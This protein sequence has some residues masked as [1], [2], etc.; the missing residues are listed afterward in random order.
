MSDTTQERGQRQRRLTPEQR[1]ILESF[2]DLQN[3]LGRGTRRIGG[4]V[5]VQVLHPTLNRNGRID[6]G[7][8]L[9]QAASELVLIDRS[10][11]SVAVLVGAGGQQTFPNHTLAVRFTVL[12]AAGQVVARGSAPRSPVTSSATPPAE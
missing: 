9:P 10:G 11:R 5:Q 3:L 2:A 4:A 1:R 12:D 8:P 7:Q 6:F